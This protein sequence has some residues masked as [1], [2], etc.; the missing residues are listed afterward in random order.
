MSCEHGNAT[1]I[2]SL[3]EAG[4]VYYCWDC[5]GYIE[6][7]DAKHEFGNRHLL[8]EELDALIAE[9]IKLARANLINEIG[10]KLDEFAGA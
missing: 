1:Y 4:E 8:P 5:Q 7:G 9:A 2:E 10:A 6:I 3:D